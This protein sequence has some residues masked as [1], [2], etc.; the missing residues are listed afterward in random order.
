MCIAGVLDGETLSVWNESLGLFVLQSFALVY[1]FLCFCD[2]LLM[3]Y[4]ILY[5]ATDQ[6]FFFNLK[7]YKIMIPLVWH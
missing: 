4:L 5:V 7:Y 2:V 3:F 6:Y 1:V